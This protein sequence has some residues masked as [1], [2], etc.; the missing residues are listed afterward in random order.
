MADRTRDVFTVL[1]LLGEYKGYVEEGSIQFLRKG[2]ADVGRLLLDLIEVFGGEVKNGKVVKKKKGKDSD[3]IDWYEAH[4]TGRELWHKLASCALNSIDPNSKGNSKLFE[5][6]DDATKFEDLLYGLDDYYRDH[7]LHSLWVYMLG[8]RLLRNHLSKIYDNKLNWYLFNDIKRDREDYEYPPDLVT[9]SEMKKEQLF[10]GVNQHKDA[11]WCIIALCHDLGYSLAK[12]KSLNEKVQNVL[13][14]FDVPD[15]Q[16]VGYS[17]DIEHQYLITQFLELMAMEVRMGPNE[18]YREIET[19]LKD[20]FSKEDVRKPR[21]KPRENWDKLKAEWNTLKKTKGKLKE[22]VHKNRIEK[23]IKKVPKVLKDNLLIKCYRDDSTYWRL[24][25]ALERK[26]HGILSSYLIYKIL[27][28][29]AESTVRGAAEEWGLDD[30]EAKKNII[31]GDILFAIAQHEFNFAHLNELGSLADILIVCDELEEF[32]R[33]GRELLTRK[34]YETTADTSISFD[35][36]E[37]DEEVEPGNDIKINM[38]YLSKH[39]KPEDCLDFFRRKA[40]RLCSIYSLNPSPEDEGEQK[41]EKESYCTITSIEMKV[42]WK[43]KREEVEKSKTASIKIGDDFWIRLSKEAGIIEGKLPK[44]ADSKYKNKN[45]KKGKKK[46]RC[47]D[48]E[49]RV[50][51]GK[52]IIPLKKWLGIKD[53]NG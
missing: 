30:N 52:D 10:A 46:L 53:K 42:V 49:L 47:Y 18:D 32:S 43:P 26:E 7:T 25:K 16:H 22:K 9:V 48:D 34:Y 4:K 21:G 44:C 15:F 40:E 38:K 41:K 36:V 20:Y 11:I 23:I 8:E 51:V 1:S 24:C 35:P 39:K 3:K 6:L 45:F 2:Q 28:I 13:K 37:E 14:Y 31:R 29:F 33:Y 12:L 5:Y 27:G 19:K 17:L 50:I